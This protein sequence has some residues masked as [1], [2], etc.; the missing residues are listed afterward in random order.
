MDRFEQGDKVRFDGEVYDF[1]YYVNDERCVLY[2]EGERNM[3]DS[4]S[5]KIDGVTD[6]H[7]YLPNEERKILNIESQIC[8]SESSFIY[9]SALVNLAAEAGYTH[10]YDHWGHKAWDEY[11]MKEAKQQ[12]CVKHVEDENENEYR[13]DDDLPF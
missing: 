12:F 6:A 7:R 4:I 1:G 9:L 10:V 8:D 11:T 2:Y 13:D 5:V 3:Q